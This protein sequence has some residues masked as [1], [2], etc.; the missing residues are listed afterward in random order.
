MNQ[1]SLKKGDDIL[2]HITAVP[3]AQAGL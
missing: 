2:S 1:G 3:S